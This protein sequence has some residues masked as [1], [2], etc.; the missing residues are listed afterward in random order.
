M[1]MAMATDTDQAKLV[2]L[3]C[4]FFRTLLKENVHAKDFGAKAVSS[5]KSSTVR[6]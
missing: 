3:V 2:F 1:A 5:M 4:I 6:R